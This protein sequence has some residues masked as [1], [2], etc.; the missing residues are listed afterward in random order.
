MVREKCK[1]INA[2]MQTNQGLQST[3]L[4]YILKINAEQ[5]NL[6]KAEDRNKE[7]KSLRIRGMDTLEEKQW[8][9]KQFNEDTGS[10]TPALSRTSPMAKEYSVT[11]KSINMVLQMKG[12]NGMRNKVFMIPST[13]RCQ[14]PSY[15][16]LAWAHRRQPRSAWSHQFQEGWGYP[17]AQQMLHGL[18]R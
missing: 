1:I 15:G 6:W 12:M 5:S 18:C 2:Y 10:F 11:L 13:N 17:Q 9:R 3:I 14:N 16:H 8:S 7:R 4:I